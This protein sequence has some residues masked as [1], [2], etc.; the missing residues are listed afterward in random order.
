M[1]YLYNLIL[2]RPIYNALVFLYNAIPW[3]DMGL[4]I[5][6]LT[7]V[8]KAV[9]YPLNVKALKSQKALQELEPKMSAIKE[10]FKDN[11]Q[12]QAKAIMDLYKQEKVSPFSSCLPLLLQLPFL[13]AIYQA[14]QASLASNGFEVLYPFVA[15]P[16]TVNSMSLGFLNLAKPSYVLAILAGVSQFFQTKMLTA[17]QPPKSAGAGAKDEGQMAM[18]NKQMQY[19]MPLM[20]V[21]IGVSLPAGLTLYWFVMTILTIGQQWLIFRPVKKTEIKKS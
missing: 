4:A 7:I 11:K 10:R 1:L 3:H 12:E 19:M 18:M 2:Y 8:L 6:I 13:I 21:F 5:I 15:N 17:K 14:M 20:T 9:L 16:G